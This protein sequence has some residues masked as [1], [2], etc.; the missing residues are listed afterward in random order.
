MVCH[1]ANKIEASRLALE[2]ET[3]LSEFSL[4]IYGPL[5]LL[6]A[7]DTDLTRAGLPENL[8]EIWPEWVSRLELPDETCIILYLMS[9]ND[10]I[11]Q[12][13]VPASAMNP[14]I[15]AWADDLVT[16]PEPGL[17]N[18]GILSSEPT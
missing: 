4:E 5:W 7:G 2:P 1:L 16:E 15:R 6:E 3:P 17:P 11:D 10:A 18:A 13:Y 12:I 9:D 14:E 8:A